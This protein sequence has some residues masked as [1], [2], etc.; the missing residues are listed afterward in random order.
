MDFLRNYG[1]V[2]LLG[3]QYHVKFGTNQTAIFCDLQ[4]CDLK[5]YYS[6]IPNLATMELGG[7]ELRDLLYSAL[8]DGCRVAKKDF[9]LTVEEV[10]DLLDVL[11]QE[12]PA[13][14]AEVFA[15][16]APKQP[17]VPDPNGEEEKAPKANQ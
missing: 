13:K 14:L 2:E 7:S 16:M 5:K 6:I 9:S 4:K 11:I 3:E 15:I 12:E 17:G 10:A 1:T 8:K